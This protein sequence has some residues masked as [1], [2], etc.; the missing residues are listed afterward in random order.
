[1]RGLTRNETSAI[2]NYLED[3]AVLLGHKGKPWL[4]IAQD[5]AVVL[6]NTT[7]FKPPGV[8]KADENL[9]N[10]VCKEEKELTKTQA[11]AR[12]KW[13]DEQLLQMHHSKHWFDV[14]FRDDFHF[15]IGPQTTSVGSKYHYGPKNVYRKKVTTKDTK[16]RHGR[17]SILSF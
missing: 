6:P 12:E 13:T 10:A 3:P 8:C 11:K 2:S 7:H 16:R 5:A 9:I 14:A 4:D 17:R 15:G 1:M